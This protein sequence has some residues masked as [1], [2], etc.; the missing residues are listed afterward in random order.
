MPVVRVARNVPTRREPSPVIEEKEIKYNEMQTER[1]EKMSLFK[2]EIFR[3]HCTFIMLDID[4]L[5][6][7]VPE[8]PFCKMDKEMDEIEEEDGEVVDAVVNMNLGD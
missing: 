7:L 2:N 3:D 1:E 4:D 5:G 6:C 8:C